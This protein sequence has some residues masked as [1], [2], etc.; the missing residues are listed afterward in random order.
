MIC[1]VS[2]LV[3]SISRVWNLRS[4][5]TKVACSHTGMNLGFE[6]P[7]STNSEVQGCLLVCFCFFISLKSGLILWS[8]FIRQKGGYIC[9]CLL[10][11]KLG[12]SHS[13][14]PLFSSVMYIVKTTDVESNCHSKCL[15]R[16]CIIL[17]CNTE[18]KSCGLGICF[19]YGT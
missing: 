5:N 6:I 13:Q 17:Q 14:C 12:H 1:V 10:V 9:H 16:P 15:Q 3:M 2:T 19:Q 4:R 8:L 11:I 7:H 18:T